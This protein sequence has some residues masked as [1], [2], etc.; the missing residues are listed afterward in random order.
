MQF[1]TILNKE[2]ISWY[3]CFISNPYTNN[4]SNPSKPKRVEKFFAEFKKSH[5]YKTIQQIYDELVESIADSKYFND[6]G[7]QLYMDSNDDYYSALEAEAINKC[8]DK[9]IE[10]DPKNSVAYYNKG[11]ALGILNK[12]DDAIECLDKAKSLGYRSDIISIEYDNKDLLYSTNKKF[13]IKQ[14]A[15]SDYKNISEQN[16]YESN[17][18][19]AAKLCTKFL[20]CLFYKDEEVNNYKK[21][22]IDKLNFYNNRDSHEMSWYD[23]IKSEILIN[24]A[25]VYLK[26]KMKSSKLERLII[27]FLAGVENS[28]TLYFMNS[29]GGLFFKAN[30]LMYFRDYLG[31]IDRFKLRTLLL[32][33][34]I[35]LLNKFTVNFN[36]LAFLPYL[37]YH[38]YNK[39]SYRFII[40]RLSSMDNFYRFVSGATEITE[41]IIYDRDFLNEERIFLYEEAKV[42][43]NEAIKKGAH[44]PEELYL[45]LDGKK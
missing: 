14:F 32:F 28:A 35:Y 25:R 6:K 38:F 20:E 36:E 41:T 30:S 37:F 1:K 13:I 33:L 26:S 8:F 16:F 44:Y 29:Y 21:T 39:I 45:I 18:E 31:D 11:D 3:S 15:Y 4:E 40:K 43:L 27:R 10:L 34:G 9:A 12:V 2:K 19:E 42:R 5:M 17:Y 24:F 7:I 23:S 22:P